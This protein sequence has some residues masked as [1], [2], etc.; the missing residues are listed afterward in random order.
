MS[1]ASEIADLETNLQAAK[2]AV[3]V[4]GGTVGDTG[5]AGL[6]SEIQSIPNGGGSEEPSSGGHI[7]GYDTTT[8][9]ITGNGFGSSTGTVYLLDR[10]TNTYVAQPTSSWSSSSITL[11][12]P[13][14]TA[15]IEGTTSLSVV[16][17][18]GEWATKWLITGG[19]T[20]PD[21]G[22]VY[23]QDSTTRQVRTIAITSQ[24]DFN[25][26]F[27]NNTYGNVPSVATTIG[28]DTF[29][30]DEIVG[31]QFGSSTTATALTGLGASYHFLSYAAN[32]NQPI[33]L[34]SVITGIP[35]RFGYYWSNFNQPLVLSN[36]ITSLPDYFLVNAVNFGQPIDLS[37][38]TTIGNYVFEYA[39]RFNQ[40]LDLSSVTTIGNYFFAGY[41]YQTEYRAMAFNS[42]ITFRDLTTVGNYFMAYCSAF[43]SK[44][45][46]PNT[47][48]TIGTYFMHQCCSFNKPM[49][50]SATA[51]AQLP[52]YFMDNCTDFNSEFKFPSG[53]TT[54]GGYCLYNCYAF[55]QPITIPS[56]VTTIGTYFLGIALSFNQPLVIPQGVT[57]LAT[58]L[59]YAASSMNQ[60]LT[61]PSSLTSVG[62]YMLYNANGFCNLETNTT[63]VPTTNAQYALSTTSNT[64][65]MY[66]KGVTITGSGAAN[67]VAMGNR[68]S[69]PY[70]K[71]INGN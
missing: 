41:F 2:N 47:L 37:K 26:L 18:N 49:D 23:V 55:N 34:P 48:A 54:I 42:D 20:V 25:K 4:K 28:S 33:V 27:D 17:S 13:I 31:F 65:K 30:R 66:V 61:L 44:I 8:G 64:A 40:P 70:R 60:K 7:T 43:N 16:D 22:K 3:T 32:F 53:L 21:W 6:A 50:L 29:Y 51:V 14:D 58:S 68:T 12:T 9:V 19:V 15:S 46:L 24:T 63:A 1:I 35:Q 71:L 36:N 38:I 5:L 45:T 59:L 56:T 10:A 39:F 11:A 52:D 62:S 57:S 69:S 67:W